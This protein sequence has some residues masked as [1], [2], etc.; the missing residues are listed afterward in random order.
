MD[1]DQRGKNDLQDRVSRHNLC[2]LVAEVAAASASPYWA[3]PDAEGLQDAARLGL[4]VHA[5][6][7]QPLPGRQK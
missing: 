7:D 4:D 6:L 5:D 2:Q 1:R 3:E